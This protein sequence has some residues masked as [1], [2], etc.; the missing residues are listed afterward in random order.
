[1][2]RTTGCCISLRCALDNDN[3]GHQNSDGVVSKGYFR[4]E[5]SDARRSVKR[6]TGSF[7]VAL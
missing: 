5:A 4:I 7:E 6:N 3:P 1:M 2:E